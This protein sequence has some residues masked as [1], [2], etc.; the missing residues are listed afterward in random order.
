MTYSELGAE[1]RAEKTNSA[2][3]IDGVDCAWLPFFAQVT[4]LLPGKKM[5]PILKKFA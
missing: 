2:D 4:R 1:L 3:A 5:H